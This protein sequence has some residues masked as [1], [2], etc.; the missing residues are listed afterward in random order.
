MKNRLKNYFA[1]RNML[2]EIALDCFGSLL[3]AIGIY[4]FAAN[5]DFAPGGISGIAIIINHFFSFLPIGTV[6]L[7]LNLPIILGS[8]RYLGI[9]YLLRTFRTLVISAFFM[10]VVVPMF[11]MYDGMHLLAAM[12]AGAFSGIGLAIIYNNNTCT[13]GT[14][15]V[16]MSARKV[17]PHL[18]IGQITM[19]I[20]GSI[21]FFGWLVFG[22]IDAVLYGFLFT[23]VSTFF[24]DRMMYGF[25]TGKLAMI[26]SEQSTELA[27][28]IGQQIRRGSTRLLAKGSY[29]GA[30]KDVLL[31]ACNRTQQVML[32]KIVKDVDPEAFVIILDYNEVRGQGF[33]PHE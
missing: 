6:A 13:G 20:D 12:Y 1:G 4:Y 5:A 27:K 28:I 23:F 11:G 16:I 24:I 26:I 7:V 8:K 9:G 21:I 25:T 18:S 31:C 29:S 2:R 10:D 32:N 33:L 15:L 22:N 3:Y 17:K 30:D 14:D 19:V